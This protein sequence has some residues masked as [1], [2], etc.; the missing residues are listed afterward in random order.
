MVSLLKFSSHE[1]ER[2][3]KFGWTFVRSEY[4][5]QY[6]SEFLFDPISQISPIASVRQDFHQARK[7]ISEFL[8]GLWGALA[9]M[10]VGFMDCDG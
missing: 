10:Q 3:L 9:V 5:L 4:D 2:S 6:P 7:F 1:K 8:Y